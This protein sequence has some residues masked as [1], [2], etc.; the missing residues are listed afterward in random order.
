MEEHVLKISEVIK[1]F[2]KEL[3]T[4]SCVVHREHH[5]RKEQ[6]EREWKLQL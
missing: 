2:N 3:R 1:G 5:Y 4:Y 6:E